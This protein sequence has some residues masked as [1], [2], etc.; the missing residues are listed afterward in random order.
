M[1][2]DPE[3]ITKQIAQDVYRSWLYYSKLCGDQHSNRMKMLGNGISPA[4]TKKCAEATANF[5]A[6]QLSNPGEETEAFK[7]AEKRRIAG[8]NGAIGT[9]PKEETAEQTMARLGMKSYSD[10]LAS[11]KP[12]PCAEGSFA[13]GRKK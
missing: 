10:S 9:M 11:G 4:K 2:R 3:Q 1:E 6:F 12:D 5:K 13:C 7:A 8:A